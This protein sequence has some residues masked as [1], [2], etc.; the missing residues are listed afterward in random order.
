MANISI[1]A[2]GMIGTDS[3][4]PISWA[5]QPHWKTATTTPYAAPTPRT[6]RTA[7]FN[8]TSTDRNTIMRTRNDN[9]M[10]APRNQGIRCCN[11]DDTSAVIAVEPVI[12]TSTSAPS[13]AAGMVSSRRCSSRSLVRAS[14]G[15]VVGVSVRIARLSASF[16]TGSSTEATPGSSARAVESVSSVVSGISPLPASRTPWK[17]QAVRQQHGGATGVH[18]GAE[19]DALAVFEL[20]RD[21]AGT[22]LLEAV[23]KILDAAHS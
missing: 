12:D 6:L 15:D 1:G 16:L 19:E 23:T 20:A 11:R 18:V 2:S 7:A 9:P 17:A 10:T 3:C 21:H 4:T 5:P 13:T 14:C 22:Q 8:G